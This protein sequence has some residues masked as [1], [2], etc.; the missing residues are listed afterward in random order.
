V[1]K[2]NQVVALKSLSSMIISLLSIIGILFTIL[3]YFIVSPSISSMQQSSSQLF[4]GLVEVSDATLYNNNVAITIVGSHKMFLESMETA[5]NSTKDGLRASRESFAKL[6][7]LSGYDYSN[8]TIRLKESED[9]LNQ[10]MIEIEDSIQKMEVYEAGMSPLKGDIS[11]RISKYADSFSLSL[12]SLSTLFTGMTVILLLL[13]ISIV[14]L[15]AEN[16]LN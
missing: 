2:Q 7:Q 16:L 6:S 14:L 1:E 5:L 8:E 9:A 3:V 4:G 13:F 11:A 10:L 12:A 15:S